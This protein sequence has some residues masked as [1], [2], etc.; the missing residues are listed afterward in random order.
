M[1]ETHGQSPPSH[2]TLISANLCGSGFHR[3]H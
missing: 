2:W 1:Q 3:S